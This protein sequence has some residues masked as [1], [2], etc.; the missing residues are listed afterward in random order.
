MTNQG[1][2]TAKYANYAKK[3]P[4]ATEAT[5][6]TEEIINNGPFRFTPVQP[7]INA[8]AQLKTKHSKPKTARLPQLNT[9]DSKLATVL[10]PCLFPRTT[11]I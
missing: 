2:Q 11:I 9:E 5:E 3:R 6:D 10:L 4:F 7:Q 1:F 8:D